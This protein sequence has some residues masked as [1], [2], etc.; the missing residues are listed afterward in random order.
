MLKEEGFLENATLAGCQEGKTR[1]PTN[2][3]VKRASAFNAHRVSR[4]FTTNTRKTES[5]CGHTSAMTD[6]CRRY[7]AEK[8]LNDRDIVRGSQFHLLLVV[9]IHHRSPS[10]Y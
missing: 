4:N 3:L 1:K 10:D 6:D 7:L 9:L 2:L 8:V 5:T